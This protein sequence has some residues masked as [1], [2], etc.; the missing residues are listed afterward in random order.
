MA[1]ATVPPR[2]RAIVDLGAIRHNYRRLRD[3]TGVGQELMCVVKADAYGHGAFEVCRALLKAG[4]RQ[5]AVA[6]LD[7][8]AALAESGFH[9]PVAVLFGLLEGEER[10]AAALGVQPMINSLEQLER[11]KG[12]ARRLGKRL[13]CHLMLNTGLNRL[14]LDLVREGSAAFERVCSAT[15]WLRFEGVATHY[16]SPEN[17]QTRQTGL[18]DATFRRLVRSLRRRGVAPRGV[19]AQASAAIVHRGSDQ[20]VLGGLTMARPGLALYGYVLPAVGRDRQRAPR[21]RPALEWRARLLGLHD[22]SMGASVGYAGSFVAP[23]DMRV[24]VLSVGFADGLDRRLAN[25]GAVLLRGVEC[26]IVGAISMDLTVVDVTAATNAAESD[27]CV[28]MGR[29]WQTAEGISDLIGGV[30]YEVLCGIATRVPR[31]Y[32]PARHPA[33]RDAQ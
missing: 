8:A 31:E 28:V 11:W 3:L 2:T 5:F 13:P 12:E 19:H 17:F 30:P 33:P 10:E 7:E 23:R 1:A 9:R 21:L 27:E 14:G 29:S 4:A 15:P 24:G 25:R 26:S 16:A 6:T 20:I 22:V 18:Q 32:L